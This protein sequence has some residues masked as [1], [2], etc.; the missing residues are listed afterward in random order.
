MVWNIQCTNNCSVGGFRASNIVDL[1]DSHRD[2]E[3][4]WFLCN[5]GN[6]GYVQKKYK[7]QEKDESWEPILKGAIRL[8]DKGDTYQPFVFLVVDDERDVDGDTIEAIWFSYYKDTRRDGGRLKLGYGPG[9][10]PVLGKAA[11]SSLYSNLIG[12]GYLDQQ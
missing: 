11:I 1:L 4:G 12:R 3:T 8:G 2:E 9:G 6:R 10:P 7:L 5:C